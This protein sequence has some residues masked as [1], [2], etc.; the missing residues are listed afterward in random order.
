MKIKLRDLTKEQYDKRKDKEC[1][2]K[3]TDCKKCPFYN[4][5]CLYS[6]YHS[7]WIYHK[8]LYSDKFL[9]QEI[10]IDEPI[11]NRKRKRIF[12]SSY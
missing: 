11:F 7:C 10:E 2:V 3:N 1:L 6:R 9:D 5:T 12:K 8:D 4:V